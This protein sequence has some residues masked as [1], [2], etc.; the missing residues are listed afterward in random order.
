[1]DG[2]DAPPPPPLPPIPPQPR[3]L[4]LELIDANGIVWNVGTGPV[5]LTTGGIDGLGQPTAQWQI[6]EAPGVHGQRAVGWRLKARDLFLPVRF[7]GEAETDATGIQRQ[8][9]DGIAIG[10]YVTFRVTDHT[11]ATRSIAMRLKDDGGVTYKRQPYL[12]Q[13]DAIG[14]TFTADDPWWYGDESRASFQFSAEEGV[15]FFGDDEGAPDF[16]I[17]AGSGVSG[18]LKLDN[19]GDTSAPVVWEVTGDDAESFRIDVDG[20]RIELS[21]PITNGSQLVLNT[22]PRALTAELDGSLYPYRLFDSIDFAPI[23]EKTTSRVA[24]SLVG[25]GTIVG[26]ARPRYFRGF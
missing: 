3:F 26:Y 12:I 23:P 5:R 11:G 4:L 16:H 14:L 15:D 13:P 20:H 25:S 17:S 2:A 24:I 7:K 9:W 10:K 19:P 1:M 6:S 18:V 21:Q 22:D 8:F